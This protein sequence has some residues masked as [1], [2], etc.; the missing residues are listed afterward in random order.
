MKHFLFDFDGVIIKKHNFAQGVEDTHGLPAE[1]MYQFFNT[2]LRKSL[3]G[4]GSLVE[5]LELEAKNLGWNGSGREI[6][7]A[8]YLEH[9]Q[10][11]EELIKFIQTDLS[12]QAICSIAT[13]QDRDRLFQIRQE[14]VVKDCFHRVY[15]SCEMGV[16]KPD[17]NYFK[18]LYQ[19]LQKD[20]GPLQ[21]SALLFIDDLAENVASAQSFGI[22]AYHYKEYG[23]FKEF[24]R[25]L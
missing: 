8:L 16:A 4:E 10:F 14:P 17:P 9:Q 18:Y 1:R 22:P 7:D 5:Y 23:A 2:Y 3:C 20:F 25:S 11:D 21:K 24:I 15:G 13:N 6:F 19:S 12:P